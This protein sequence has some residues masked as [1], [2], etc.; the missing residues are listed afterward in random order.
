M[1]VA[2]MVIF[3]LVSVLGTAA[4]MIPEAAIGTATETV[5]LALFLGVMA[6]GV[7]VALYVAV[8]EKKGHTRVQYGLS[9]KALNAAVLFARGVINAR[10]AQITMLRVSTSTKFINDRTGL[11]STR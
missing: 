2:A 7:G 8:S 5:A 3:A 1:L 9:V 4:A 6:I 11:L 10:Y